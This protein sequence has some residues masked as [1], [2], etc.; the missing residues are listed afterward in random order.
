MSLLTTNEE[1]EEVS[2]KDEEVK[3]EIVNEEEDKKEVEDTQ[4]KDDDIQDIDLS[5]TRKKRFRIDGDNNRIIEIDTSDIRIVTRLETVY[6]KLQ[7]L[8]DKAHKSI[9][10]TEDED[11]ENSTLSEKLDKIDRDMRDLVD[12]LFNAK[13]ADI[14]APDGTMYDPYAGKLRFEHIID[15]VGNLYEKNLTKEINLISARVKKHTSKYIK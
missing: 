14:C 3:E 15:V 4:S 10:E 2:V 9:L 5:A 6:N 8:S 12:E 7:K 11:I 1:K 13:V